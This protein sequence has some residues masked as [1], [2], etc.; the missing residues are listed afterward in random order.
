MRGNVS[1]APRHAEEKLRLPPAPGSAPQNEIDSSTPKPQTKSVLPIV[2]REL[3]VASRKRTLV[4]A[5]V[6]AALVGFLFLLGSA[7]IYSGSTTAGLRLFHGFAQLAYW[8]CFFGGVL[9]T[10]DC[11]SVERRNGT[12]G[13]LFLTDLRGHD[14]VLGK[15]TAKSIG[16]LFCLVAILPMLAI[17][18]LMGGVS[19]GEF[20]RSVLV[21]LNTLFLSVAVG[22]AISVYSKSRSAIAVGIFAMFLIA[23]SLPAVHALFDL[24]PRRDALLVGFYPPA[25]LSLSETTLFANDATPFWVNIAST[26]VL[27]WL[28]LGVACRQITQTWQ[29]RPPLG[30]WRT[31]EQWKREVTLGSRAYRT[32]TRSRLL[33]ENPILWL[34]GRDRSLRLG[35]T[36]VFLAVAAGCFLVNFSRALHWSH[37][38]APISSFVFLG[39]LLLLLVSFDA[40]SYLVERRREEAL[41]LIL[42]T[43]LTTGMIVRGHWL[44]CRRL[45]RG[46]MVTLVGYAVAWAIAASWHALPRHRWL[47]IVFPGVML[48]NL[49]VVGR[50]TVWCAMSYSLRAR[51][52]TLPAIGALATNVLLPL[53]ML[54]LFCIPTFHYSENNALFV[55]LLVSLLLI[56]NASVFGHIARAR[57]HE[58][59]RRSLTESRPRRVPRTEP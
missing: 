40:A 57:L 12:L 21:L 2:R 16:G 32:R 43:P 1:T 59:L 25:A 18:I 37:I 39:L 3:L 34:Q 19:A 6:G 9:L 58:Q 50:A 48:I 44:A 7:G 13:L 20:W 53:L 27:G 11:L 51:W 33:D 10:A 8:G 49:F 15:L 55:S 38:A 17:P 35:V 56:A 36:V 22:M 29:T 30:L 45:F 23:C 31:W 52:S 28:L 26:H 4:L 24:W 54:G 14:V 47:A 42:S 5:R 46:P 41:E